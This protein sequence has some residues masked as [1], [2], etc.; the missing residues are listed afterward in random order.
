[1]PV[2]A[3]TVMAR[4]KITV[5]SPLLVPVPPAV[6]TATLLVVA[7]AGTV[8]VICVAELTEKLVAA[9]PPKR[10]A[11]APLKLVPVIVTEAPTGPD[12]GVKSVTVGAA[13]N[14]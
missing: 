12:A 14:V 10:T 2:I 5:K 13:R 6:V 4:G 7:P 9:V 8:A 3:G 1:M 11:V